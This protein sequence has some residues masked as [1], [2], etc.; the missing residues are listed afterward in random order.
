VHQPLVSCGNGL[1]N[2]KAH[3]PFYQHMI[4]KSM[5]GYHIH[6]T[7]IFCTIK[8]QK[9]YEKTANKCSLTWKNNGA[10]GPDD[11]QHSKYWIAH[12][13]NTDPNFV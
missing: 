12:W 4:S 6:V 13:L 2:Q 10:L 8:Y 1:C 3:D 9:M 7:D 5:K 11:P